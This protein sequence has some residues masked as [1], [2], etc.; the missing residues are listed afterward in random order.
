MSKVD[1]VVAPSNIM[2]LKEQSLLGREALFHHHHH[3]KNV[4]ML[5]WHVFIVIIL[6]DGLFGERS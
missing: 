1:F 4:W 3:C 6:F 5:S 2:V